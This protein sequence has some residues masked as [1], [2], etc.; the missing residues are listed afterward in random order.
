[1]ADNVPAH[2]P[3][4]IL[5]MKIA[6]YVPSWPPGASPNGI[7]TYASHIVPALRS[8]GHE[9]FIVTGGSSKDAENADTISIARLHEASNVFAKI[10][11]RIAPDST[12]PSLISL[13]VRKLVSNVGIDVFEIEESFGWSFATSRLNIVPVVVRLHGPCC[14]MGQFDRTP[15]ARKIALEGR[16]IQSANYVTACSANVVNGVKRFYNFSLPKSRTIPN[17]VDTVPEED[18]WKPD[19]CDAESL[20]FVGRFDTLKGGDLVLN[21]FAALAK[22][23]QRLKLTFVGPDRGLATSTED[24]SLAQFVRQNI[25]E[26]VRSRIDYRGQLSH[27]EVMALR[28]RHFVTIVASRYEPQGYVV[29]EALSRGCPVIATAVGGIPEFVTDR[30]NGLLVPAESVEALASACKL[31]LDNKDLAARIGRQAWV[32]CRE[33]YSPESIAKQTISAYQDAIKAAKHAP[34]F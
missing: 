31:L 24:L 33:L 16:A 14:L 28:K 18:I 9:V 29:M 17:P 34:N 32:S 23:R 15:D 10:K 7:V 3:Q 30:Y 2:F 12:A 8:R 21:A 26:S 25:P 5:P 1:L 6:L 13:A 11:H 22:I 27:S 19:N 4:F 20:L